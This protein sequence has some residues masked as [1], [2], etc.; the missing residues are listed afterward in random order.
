MKYQ[1]GFALLLPDS[2]NN[3]IRD[4]ELT[5]SDALDNQQGLS[6]PPHITVKRPFEVSSRELL[7]QLDE[8]L[9]EFSD[10]YSSPSL[11]YGMTRDFGK[12]SLVLLV[13]DPDPVEMLH[14]QLLEICS[15]FSVMPDKFEGDN[16]IPHT[17]VAMGLNS[18]NIHQANEILAQSKLQGIEFTPTHLAI[19][20]FTDNHWVTYSMHALSDAK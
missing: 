20:I 4:I 12:T 16:F 15:K 19:L 7:V 6:Q 17:T 8:M 5:V 18:A 9:R 14:V 10:F 2:L 3:L 1:I 11:K 13:D